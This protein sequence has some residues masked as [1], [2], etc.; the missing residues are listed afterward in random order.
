MLDDLAVKFDMFG[1]ELVNGTYLSLY[2]RTFTE[3][4]FKSNIVPLV[5]GSMVNLVL[6]P[7]GNLGTRGIMVKELTCFNSLIELFKTIPVV[8]STER[9][10]S[11]FIL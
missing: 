5:N 10:I 8:K 1:I 2:P 11:G 6:A 7:I 3:N 4:T 9:F